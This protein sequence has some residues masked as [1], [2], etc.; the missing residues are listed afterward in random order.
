VPVTFSGRN[1]VC[2]SSFP[3]SAFDPGELEGPLDLGRP[4]TRV[5]NPDL[6]VAQY[7]DLRILIAAGRFQADFR[8]GA[9]RGLIRDACPLL[10]D[11]V[12]NFRP[13]AVGFNG[14]LN[15]ELGDEDEDPIGRIFNATA[16]A[17]RVGGQNARGGFK[18]TYMADD[19]RWT[20]SVE[21][22]ADAANVWLASVNR[23]YDSLPTGDL[24][25]SA[26][27]WFAALNEELPNQFRALTS[28]QADDGNSGSP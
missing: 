1:L 9:S 24:Q 18:V 14:T 7:S 22:D 12:A 21:P 10:L 16:L 15:V 17:E 25:Q 2:L 6:A 4:E 8:V 28:G 26:I 19:A 3:P 23:H 13:T 11:L 27:S 20:F 5:D